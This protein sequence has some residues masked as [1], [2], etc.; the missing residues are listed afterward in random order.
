MQHIW[1]K[2]KARTEYEWMK[3][4]LVTDKTTQAVVFGQYLG[5]EG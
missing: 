1:I 2:D 5:E 4:L 3:F